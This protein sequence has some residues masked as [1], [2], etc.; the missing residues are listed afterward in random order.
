M[1]ID[2]LLYMVFMLGRRFAEVKQTSGYSLDIVV[3]YPSEAIPQRIYWNCMVVIARTI[4]KVLSSE[5]L[6]YH[7]S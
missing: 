7:S 4:T 3:L 2:T 5:V 1:I 6:N